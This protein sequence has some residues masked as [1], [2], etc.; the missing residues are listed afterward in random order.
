M[1]KELSGINVSQIR[2]WHE[3]RLKL[4]E[5]NKTNLMKLGSLKEQLKLNDKT[6]KRLTD[7]EKKLR[8]QEDKAKEINKRLSFINKAIKVIENTK[9]SI[10]QETRKYHRK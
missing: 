1:N 2:T 9:N 4:E 5:A 7:E 10:M 8:S 3:E 6:I